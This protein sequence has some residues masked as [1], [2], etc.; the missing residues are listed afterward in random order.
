[1]SKKLLLAD[2]SITIQKVIGITFANE[3]YELTVVDNGDA[4]LEK[5]A[6]IRP[7][8]ILADV[9]MPG[10]NGYEVCSAVKGNPA[11]AGIPVLLLT[12]TF[13][14]FDE[15][16]ARA[17]GADSWISKPF[18]SQALIDRVE[19][20]LSQGTRSRPAASPIFAAPAAPLQS[21]PVP[22]V[23][24]PSFG[25]ASETWDVA[26][27][28]EAVEAA[29][30]QSGNAAPVVE[31]DPWGAIS[32]DEQELPPASPPEFA[33]A[34][35]QVVGEEMFA[36]EEAG[37]FTFEEDRPQPPAE[38]MAITPEPLERPAGG[39][40]DDLEEDV[41]ALDESDILE[42]EDLPASEDFLFEEESPRAEN[43]DEFVF[44]EDEPATTAVEAGVGGR[45]EPAAAADDFGFA[46]L[47]PVAEG[48]ADLVFG[49][50]EY[51][52]AEA[53]ETPYREEE[54]A[55]AAVAAP[56]LAEAEGEAPVEILEIA[57]E[58]APEPAAGGEGSDL[59]AL[60]GEAPAW[61]RPET[62]AAP[63]EPTVPVAERIAALSEQ[64][65]ERIVEKVAGA[66]VERLAHTILE[67]V[68][69]EV[70][71]DLAESLIR[72][73]LRRIREQAA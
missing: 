72:E 10:K 32:F 5:V 14:P 50:E 28:P 68:A 42:E 62:P 35:P 69:W 49:E 7:D 1:M 4:A 60:S 24:E 57:D 18:E 25:V 71:P 36:F 51:V 55:A 31:E 2:D 16:K 44:T 45:E 46:E 15:G 43:L 66:V 65:L 8:L 13:E 67:K 12:G 27:A 20:L 47:E 52:P 53:T 41:L 33:P 29:G 73:E 34:D 63:A 39:A 59:W 70:V 37:E 9:H 64:D 3:D 30:I 26:E 40:W 58:R 22:P 54:P 56:A 23:I 19:Q 21:E 38:P 48:T 6:A 11:H 17:A 61:S